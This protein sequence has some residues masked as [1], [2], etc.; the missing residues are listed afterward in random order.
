V[1]RCNEFIF[2][3]ANRILFIAYPHFNIYSTFILQLAV[4]KQGIILIAITIS[5]FLVAFT[6]L[7]PGIIST[8]ANAGIYTDRDAVECAPPDRTLT[9]F[10]AE[11]R[12]IPLPGWGSHSFKVNTKSDSA[13]YY[14]NQ[15]LNLFYSFHLG[16]SQSSF[17]EAR[18]HDSACAMAY[19][20]YAMASG[21]IINN[22][23]YNFSDPDIR[24]SLVKAL[25]L[26]DNPLE[27]DLI[28]AQLSRYVEDASKKRRDLFI[29]YREAMKLLH[30]KY[31]DN[32][33]VATLYA[34][35]AMMVDAR[36]WYDVAGNPYNGTD[37][38]IS[39]LEKIIEKKPD[40]PAALHYYIH[41]VEPSH[42]PER[43]IEESDK[44]LNLLPSVTHMVHMPSHIYIRTGDYKKGILSNQLAVKGYDLYR[45][46]LQNGWEGSRHLY[47]YHNV[48]MQGSNALLMGNYAAALEA[49]ETNARRFKQSDS[50]DFTS[51]GF[52]HYV[53]FLTVQPYLLKVRFG[54]WDEILETKKPLSRHI[55]HKIYWHFGQGMAQAKTK[56]IPAARASL[57][58]MKAL[59]KDGSL[60][61]R[62]G[63]RSRTIDIMQV[64]LQI[65]EGTIALAEKKDKK[66]LK[67]FMSA[68]AAEDTLHYAEPESWRIPARHY[69]GQALL[70]LSMP[71]R[72]K[73]YFDE[74]LKDH[75]NNFWAINGTLQALRQIGKKGTDIEFSEK[76]KHILEASDI[77]LSGSAY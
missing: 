30:E 69:M 45:E 31:K 3:D 18:R 14:F 72:A 1:I 66:A 12:F 58:A 65:L 71:E 55:A 67:I 2:F 41:I 47:L 32:L 29:D 57:A 4:M 36:N 21:P 48:D 11:R 49:F 51:G 16:E 37:E 10:G 26:T 68:V 53:Q 73:K 76:Y 54:K 24:H 74:D 33:E 34:D 35:A 50:A 40:H 52:G 62:L 60:D 5:A 23:T 28:K 44:L 64:P 61:A 56:N 15:G 7:R 75:P 6:A 43:A 13:Q 77:R 38:I 25:T 42:T 19:W 27:Q 17:E 59:M 9:L 8:K 20:G 63:L 22:T 70:S 39:I 46:T